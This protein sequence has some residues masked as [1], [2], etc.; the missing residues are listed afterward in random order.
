MLSCSRC[1]VVHFPVSCVR[2]PEAASRDIFNKAHAN[3]GL[4]AVVYLFIFVWCFRLESE[5]F[6]EVALQ[7]GRTLGTWLRTEIIGTAIYWSSGLHSRV[8]FV[9]DYPLER[10]FASLQPSHVI[11][12]LPLREK[13]RSHLNSLNNCWK[14]HFFYGSYLIYLDLPR[15]VKL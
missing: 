12:T 8:S 2:F 14:D 10:W 5:A 7:Y 11:F 3:L 9:E 13:W 4:E 15:C 6:S 1:H